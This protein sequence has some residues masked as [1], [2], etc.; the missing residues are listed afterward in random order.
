VPCWSDAIAPYQNIEPPT[1]KAYMQYVQFLLQE[2]FYDTT[3][4]FKELYEKD[5]AWN[6]FQI[7]V[8]RGVVLTIALLALVSSM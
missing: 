7:L 4:H 1:R 3:R 6:Y 8:K 2:N 5:D